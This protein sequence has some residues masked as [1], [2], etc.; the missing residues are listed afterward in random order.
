MVFF[1]KLVSLFN[2][3]GCSSYIIYAGSRMIAEHVIANVL[4]GIF[5]GGR[6]IIH[7]YLVEI[8]TN[9]QLERVHCSSTMLATFYV[10]VVMKSL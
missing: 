1:L 9:F 7:T 3:F 10:S 2:A 8:R 6:V 4:A 5:K